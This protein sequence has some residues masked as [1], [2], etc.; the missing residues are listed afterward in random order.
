MRHTGVFCGK[1]VN[2]RGVLFAM[3]ALVVVLPGLCYA[4]TTD[5]PDEGVHGMYERAKALFDKKKYKEAVE[6]FDR[7]EALYPFSQAAIDGS[8]MAAVAN[9]ELKNYK[10]A[11]TIAEGYIGIHPD[12]P[13]IDYAYY[14]RMISKYMMI[15]DLGLDSTEA[16]DVLGYAVEFTKMFPES[17][18]LGDVQ[19][20][21]SEVRQHISAKEFSIG[22]F[23][24][25]RG[26]YVAAIKRLSVVVEEYRDS[27]Y[28]EESVYR[29]LE[30][31][32]A[33]G[34]HDTAR[35]YLS[36]LE[37]SAWHARGVKYLEREQQAQ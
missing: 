2:L 26:E 25:K 13:S 33:I 5:V 18:Y 23:Y 36:R 14:V 22:K 35:S 7:V 29:L 27:R 20:K 16:L 34:D 21:L 8:L 31:Y 19:K 10:E 15:P 17:K 37:G 4:D 24:L 28:F 32:V 12:S 3:M 30:A 6:A 9:Y 1:T 11:A